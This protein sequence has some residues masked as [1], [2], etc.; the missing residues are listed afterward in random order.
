MILAAEITVD[1]EATLWAEAGA[2]ATV[3]IYPIGASETPVTGST[4]TSANADGERVATVTPITLIAGTYIIKGHSAHASKQ[5]WG[6]G[7]RVVPT[8]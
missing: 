1:F 3:A 7:Y 6:V 4:L 8:A 2:T 5:A